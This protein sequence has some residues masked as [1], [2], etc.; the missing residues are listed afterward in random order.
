MRDRSLDIVPEEPPIERQRRGEGLDLGQTRDLET[1][2]KEIFPG[3]FRGR[4]WRPDDWVFARAAILRRPFIEA[5]KQSPRGRRWSE[6]RSR[7]IPR[8]RST[9]GLRAA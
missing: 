8:R 6:R 5:A 4:A 3:N 2:A 9:R 1:S 7:A